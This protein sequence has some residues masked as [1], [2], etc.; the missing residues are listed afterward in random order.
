MTS[1]TSPDQRMSAARTWAESALSI[2]AEAFLPAS[3]DAS[4]RRY[5][6]IVAG[7]DSW[8]VMDAPPEHEDCRP[9][10]RVA[11][12]MRQAGMHVPRI[13]AQ[14]L[15]AG[16]LLLS[17]LGPQT[18][19]DVLNADNADRLFAQAI[20]SLLDWQRASRLGVLPA[21]D[22]PLLQRELDLFPEWYLRRYLD[23]RL[24]TDEMRAWQAV[25]AQ[26]IERALSQPQGFVH[27]DYMPRNLMVS[28]PNP[29]VL[30]F[31]DAVHGPLSYDVISLFKDAFVSWPEARVDTW[32]RSYHRL[33]LEAGIAW[34][35]YA[36]FRSIADWMGLQRHLK[37]L[38]IFARI[39]HRD[40]KPK[41]LADTPRFVRYVMDVA[42]RYPELQPLAELFSRHVLPVAQAA[43]DRTAA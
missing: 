27:R 33:S 36:E 1:D 4:F 9:F 19:L 24:T 25:C 35:D 28:E 2:V 30:D 26:L 37:V 8:I 39:W 38:G 13:I 22:A 10:V 16:F 7:A 14:D 17:D 12:L 20:A 5:F 32:L 34:P 3:S 43:S 6:R 40:G 31:Q 42:P 18:Y 41:Y 11:A 23:V 15:D 21:Y 29:G